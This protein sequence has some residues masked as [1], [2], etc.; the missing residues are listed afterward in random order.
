MKIKELFQKSFWEKEALGLKKKK[1]FILLITLPI[2]FIISIISFLIGVKSTAIIAMFSLGIILVIFPYLIYNFLEFEEIRKA[3]DNFPN[4]LRDLSQAVSAGMTIPQAVDTCAKTKYNVL[5]KYVEK[6]NIWLSWDVPFPKAWERFTKLLSRSS[7]ISRVNNIILEAYH[8]GGDIKSTL[9]SLSEN[10][11]ILKQLEAEK[12][13]IMHQQ[14]IVMYL[15]YFIFL[16]VIIGV[17]KILAPIIFIQKLGIFSGISIQEGGQMSITYFKNLFLLMTI[18]E[19]ICAGI[20]AG[21]I[22][23]ETMIAGIKH[24][25]VMFAVGVLLFSIFIIPSQLSLE[26]AIY[27]VTP[28]PE[29]KINIG[30]KVFFESSAAV[31]ASVEILTPDNEVRKVFTDNVGEFKD[32]IVAPMTAG[33]Y[34]ILITANYKKETVSVTEY[35][36]VK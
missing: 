33:R 14:I 5:S 15:I 28:T 9:G 6:L 35:I 22:S 3:E 13:S 10:V 25:V 18:V 2:P 11:S 19:S 26:T 8:G 31:G 30:G 24:V 20:I 4:F 29:A 21:E 34:R 32:I 12:K 1:L 16:G 27:P 23:E 7:L 36:T 17:Y